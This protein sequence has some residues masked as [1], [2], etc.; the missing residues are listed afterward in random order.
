MQERDRRARLQTLGSRAAFWFIALCVSVA[1]I[2]FNESDR[3]AE[4][5]L[6]LEEDPLSDE[7][8]DEIFNSSFEAEL[9]GKPVTPNLLRDAII[10]IKDGLVL[11]EAKSKR[12]WNATTSRSPTIICILILS[13]CLV[14]NSKIFAFSEL[15]WLRDKQSF[16]AKTLWNCP[17]NWGRKSEKMKRLRLTGSPRYPIVFKASRSQYY[18]IN[19]YNYYIFIA[20]TSLIA[21]I[22]L[23]NI[24]CGAG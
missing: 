17:L 7:S 8:S 6:E 15:L 1:L 5:I 21:S 9:G 14:G 16:K 3:N 4:R 19:T 10:A 13:F 18:E 22:S 12:R 24:N 23:I 20:H 2:Q 11:Y